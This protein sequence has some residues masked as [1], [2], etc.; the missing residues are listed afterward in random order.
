[1]PKILFITDIGSPWGGSEELWSKAARILIKEG[2]QVH[3]SIGWFGTVHPKVQELID[4]GIHVRFRKNNVR[5]FIR[6]V[7]DYK[8]SDFLYKFRSNIEKHINQTSPDLILFSQSHIFS[9]WRPMLYAKKNNLKYAVV[10][11]LN[12]ELSWPNDNNYKRIRQAFLSAEKC[13]FVSKGNLQLLETQLALRLPNSVIVSNP[14][15]MAEVIGLEWPQTASLNIAFVGRLD[16]IHK[17]IDILFNSFA[18]KKWQN[19]NYQLNIYGTGDI[20]LA[21]ELINFLKIKNVV[22]HGQVNNIHDIW[23]H[24]HI[25]AL[26]SRYEG[27]PL[28]MIEAMFCKRAV[29]AT[30]VAGHG[31][32]ITD[33]KTGFLAA[34]AHPKLFENK[35]EEVWQRK[36]ELEQMGINA[37]NNICSVLQDLPETSFANKIKRLLV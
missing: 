18:N 3:A 4:L 1:M 10:S 30:D 29:L 19:R 26:A 20:E 28:V 7:A 8:N 27:M 37:F 11:Q 23:R 22:F 15:N 16:F 32:L 17:G 9:A 12:S 13:F 14:F 24:N 2:Y 31:E 6:K 25:L 33:G 5:A 21:K 34:A 36:D 35:L